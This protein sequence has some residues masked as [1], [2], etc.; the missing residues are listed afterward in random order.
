MRRRTGGS[1]GGGGEPTPTPRT[2]SRSSWLPSTLE[3]VPSRHGAA[4]RSGEGRP[5][6]AGRGDAGG[7]RHPRDR[8]G[9][10][11]GERSGADGEPGRAV[12]TRPEQAGRGGT[13][14]PG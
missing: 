12:P 10:P 9:H 4:T 3:E 6:R 1:E 5:A 11:A 8:Q 7:T 2:T 14:A 13:G